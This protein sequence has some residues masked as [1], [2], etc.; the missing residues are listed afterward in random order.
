MSG[1]PTCHSP[2]SPLKRG[3]LILQEEGKFHFFYRKLIASWL[4]PLKGRESYAF[5][6]QTVE[7]G[8]KLCFR[9]PN[10]RA[11]KEGDGNCGIGKKLT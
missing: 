3:N 4:P 6:D 1:K 7:P 9:R 5:E 8:R 11:G 10:G 2:S